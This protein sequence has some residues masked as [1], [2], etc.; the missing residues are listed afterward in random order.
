MVKWKEM[1]ESL[2]M[3][4]ANQ[5]SGKYNADKWNQIETRQQNLKEK[6]N[7]PKNKKK[8]KQK[9]VKTRKGGQNE[10]FYISHLYA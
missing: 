6:T 7:K 1:N 4:K 8:K 10:L 9:I 3:W 2:L 5:F